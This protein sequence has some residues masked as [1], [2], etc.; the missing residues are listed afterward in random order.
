[1]TRISKPLT[2]QIS[3]IFALLV[4]FSLFI[5][6]GEEDKTLKPSATEG[7]TRS[8]VLLAPGQTSDENLEVSLEPEDADKEFVIEKKDDTYTI[9]IGENT[10][11]VN[12]K[13]ISG[14]TVEDVKVIYTVKCIDNDDIKNKV[15]NPEDKCK[16]E[17]IISEV[18]GVTKN[19]NE[20]T[21][22]LGDLA[23][24]SEKKLEVVVK[25][26][27]EDN[28]PPRGVSVRNEVCVEYTVPW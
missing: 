5:G 13:N 14:E 12:V 20:V 11:I 21:I 6:C 24:N 10:Y 17:V 2:K 4:T 3:L 16:G 8:L 22:D 23:E 28:L 7:E 9:L 27:S 1:M 15:E 25:L 19:E 26:V 18:D